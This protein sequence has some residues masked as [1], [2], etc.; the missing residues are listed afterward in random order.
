[1]KNRQFS[2]T[3]RIVLCIC[4][5]NL[6]LG[7]IPNIW[8]AHGHPVVKSPPLRHQYSLLIGVRRE[9]SHHGGSRFDGDEVWLV[10]VTRFWLYVP[11]HQWWLNLMIT[12]TP[13]EHLQLAE[14]WDNIR[15][16]GN[17]QRSYSLTMRDH[18]SPKWAINWS[19]R[20]PEANAYCVREKTEKISV[21]CHLFI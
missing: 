20:L 15:A 16:G 5:G 10:I 12:T 4:S 2:I 9:P 21:I 17:F 3:W 1:M 13:T 11:C 14:V 7:Y 18:N 19:Y 6:V 8:N